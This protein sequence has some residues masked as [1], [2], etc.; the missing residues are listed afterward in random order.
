M[1][2]RHSVR[3][4]RCRFLDWSPSPITALAFPPSLLISKNT[5]NSPFPILAVGR[6]NGNIE[7]WRWASS[8]SS[9]KIGNGTHQG[10]VIHQVRTSPLLWSSNTYQ[11]GY[12]SL[13]LLF[14]RLCMLLDHQKWTLWFLHGVSH[15]RQ[16]KVQVTLVR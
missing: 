2:N 10:W 1:D 4:H 11:R 9:K 8:K 15:T 16:S 5:P 13:P 7:L 3:L 6:A 14:L 12:Y